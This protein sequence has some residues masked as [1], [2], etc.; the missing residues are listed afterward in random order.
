MPREILNDQ[1]WNK[2][3]VILTELGVYTTANL[4]LNIEGIL[5][6][7][8]ASIAWRDLPLD[9]GPWNSVYRRFLRWAKAGILQK[10]FQILSNDSDNEWISIDSTYVKVHQHGTGYCTFSKESV[11]KSRGGNTTKIHL[12]ANA[13]GLPIDF[14]ITGGEKSDVKIGEKL[15]GRAPKTQFVIADRGYDSEK[16]RCMIRAKKATPVIPRKVTSV[17]GND[18]MD[19]EI[20]KYRHQVENIFARLK[21]F[22]GIATRTDKLK[23]T[24]AAGVALACAYMW[25][26]M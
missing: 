20:Y 14:E 26:A 1:L 13:H 17:I 24:Y 8:K 12:I 11:G 5:Y 3:L 21:H 16:F 23:V 9:Y 7:R 22:R 6:Y 18:D 25:L 2:L 4:R 19:W 10:I 15:I